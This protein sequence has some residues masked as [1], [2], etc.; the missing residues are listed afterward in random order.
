MAN[1]GPVVG[2]KEIALRGQRA[3]RCDSCRL[4]FR[5]IEAFKATI[6][7]GC[8]TSTP[9]ISDGGIFLGLTIVK[10]GK[11]YFAGDVGCE[12]GPP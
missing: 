4:T 7:N 3:F 10:R 8:F 12:S 9:V 6:R 2:P 11:D 5:P 1:S